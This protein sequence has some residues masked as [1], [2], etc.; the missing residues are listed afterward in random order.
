MVK[1]LIF[2]G[3]LICLWILYF[4]GISLGMAVVG[5]QDKALWEILIQSAFFALL[6]CM[7]IK[8]RDIEKKLDI[9]MAQQEPSASDKPDAEAPEPPAD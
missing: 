7:Y 6:T 9:L 8:Q 4:M 5:F 2:L 1:K 3:N